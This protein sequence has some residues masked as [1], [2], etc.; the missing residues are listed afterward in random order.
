[1]LGSKL[2]PLLGTVALAGCGGGSSSTPAAS[3]TGVA[4]AAPAAAACPR[5]DTPAPKG[6]QHLHA[7]ALRLSPSHT[8]TATLETT[9]GTI[10][11]A[12][13]AR[14]APKTT[15]SFVYLARRH[16]YDGLT[17]HRVVPGFV[18]QGGDPLG[19]GHGG[20]GYTVVERPPASTRYTQ[21]VVA[22]AKTAVQPAGASGSQFF[23]VVGAS[24][25]LPPDY[26]VL[27]R[28]S[29]GADVVARIAAVPADPQSG[30]PANAV[31]IKRLTV[32]G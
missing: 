26:A 19:S 7:P 12:L 27:G 5:V 15:A 11:L 28:V 31:V 1:M 13:D 8:Y 3:Q 6:V 9:C 25:A 16:F 23:I 29:G 22:M 2:L 18:I 14:T 24:A 21:G 20:P 32:S 4:S 17:F 10:R 30:V